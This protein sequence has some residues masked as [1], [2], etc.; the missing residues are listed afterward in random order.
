MSL[1]YLLERELLYFPAERSFRL[2]IFAHLQPN[3]SRL[4]TLGI[5]TWAEYCPS[6]YCPHD[7]NHQFL[8]IFELPRKYGNNSEL[9]DGCHPPELRSLYF[10]T[11]QTCA[12]I[13]AGEGY[14]IF[15]WRLRQVVFLAG[16]LCKAQVHNIFFISSDKVFLFQCIL[17]WRDNLSYVICKRKH[18]WIMEF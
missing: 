14:E 6:N 17:M 2:I 4:M 3:L 11:R 16:M 7:M 5:L 10:W 9:C 18:N 15:I 1:E 12:P 8:S 13:L